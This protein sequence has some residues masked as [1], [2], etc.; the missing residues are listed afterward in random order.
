MV[1]ASH[2]SLIFSGAPVHFQKRPDLADKFYDHPMPKEREREREFDL[3]LEMNP[4]K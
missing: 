2:P 3:W 1:S 4:E